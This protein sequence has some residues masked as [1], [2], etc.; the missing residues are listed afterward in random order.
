LPSSPNVQRPSRVRTPPHQLELADVWV[1][2]SRAER[3]LRRPSDAEGLAARVWH[4]PVE[5]APGALTFVCGIRIRLLIPL[6]EGALFEVS[7]WTKARF[8]APEEVDLHAAEH[9]ARASS[10]FLLWPYAR[11][12]CQEL[13]RLGGVAAPPLPLLARPSTGGRLEL[14]TG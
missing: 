9:F 4:L 8:V 13:A 14:P 10:L 5:G 7:L 6:D 3:R 2:K 12:Y 11:T 1:D